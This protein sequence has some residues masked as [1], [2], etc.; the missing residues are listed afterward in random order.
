MTD[1]SRRAVV[2]ALT[3]GALLSPLP[4]AAHRGHS[5]LS[6]VEFD[7]RTGGVTVSHRFQTHDTEPSLAV[8]APDAQSSLDD[9]DA[10]KALTDYVGAHFRVAVK[11]QVVVLAL[12]D[13]TLGADEV[14]MVYAGQVPASDVT[15]QIDVMA[16]MFADVYD[17]QVNQVNVRRVGVT[18]TL[19]FQ[20]QDAEIQSLAA[21]S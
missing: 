3:A 5:A 1:V 21:L 19:V 16:A 12:K 9:P 18:R 13:M 6:V 2:F 10:V 4:A 8:I 20:G 14:R 11:G 15:G 17:D 7:S